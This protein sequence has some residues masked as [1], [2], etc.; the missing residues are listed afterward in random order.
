MTFTQFLT[1]TKETLGALMWVNDVGELELYRIELPGVGENDRVTSWITPADQPVIKTITTENPVTVISTYNPDSNHLDI[2]GA[3]YTYN[4]LDPAY[5]YKSIVNHSYAADSETAIES[6]RY[7]D[8]LSVTR[9]TYSVVINRISP[10]LFIG[11]IVNIYSPKD[12]WND[13]KKGFNVLVVG[14]TQ[15]FNNNTSELIV[16]R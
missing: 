10:E 16:W 7:A 12:R 1:V 15:S 8:L 4:S 14:I 3:S 5:P 2:A 6:R 13:A 11:A 9:R